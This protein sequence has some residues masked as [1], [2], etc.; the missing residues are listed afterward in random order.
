MIRR[1]AISRLLITLVLLCTF[2]I[3]MLGGTYPSFQ[4]EDNPASFSPFLMVRVLSYVYLW[5]FNGWLMLCPIH[6]SHD[7]Q[8]GSIPLVQSLCDTRNLASCFLAVLL[9][10]LISKVFIS[11]KVTRI[12]WPD[13]TSAHNNLGFYLTNKTE[14]MIH[15]NE[16]I[17]LSPCHANAHSNVANIYHNSLNKTEEAIKLLYFAEECEPN[18][19]TPHLS[20]AA[21]YEDLGD[22]RLAERHYMLALELAPSQANVHHHIGLFYENREQPNTAHVPPP[23]ASKNGCNMVFIA[24][25]LASSMFESQVDANMVNAVSNNILIRVLSINR[26]ALTLD[27]AAAFYFKIGRISTSIHLYQEAYHLEPNKTSLVLHLAQALMSD[28]Q[29]AEAEQL[30][31]KH[32]D[33]DP[34]DL[35]LTIQLANVYGLNKSHNKAISLIEEFLKRRSSDLSAKQLSSLYHQIGNH[36]KDSLTF[37]LAAEHL[38]NKAR[39]HYESAYKLSPEDHLLKI[40]YD[41]FHQDVVFEESVSDSSTTNK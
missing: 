4:E 13:Y 11:N 31:I 32:L 1:Q 23:P 18:N 26:D 22:E 6:L 39:H 25:S 10:S 38:F 8:M 20:L 37:E 19:P 3:W 9:I 29:Y 2:R 7:W 15:L 5:A 24:S 40:N 41:R 28:E 33:I 17:K 34:E 14:A 21:I 36:L 35:E 30:I 12:L 27:M 16:A